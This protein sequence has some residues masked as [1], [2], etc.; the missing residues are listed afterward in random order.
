MAA[1]PWRQR[2]PK[3]EARRPQAEPQL[4]QYRVVFYREDMGTP[5]LIVTCDSELDA[6]V[7]ALEAVEDKRDEGWRVIPAHGFS[8]WR[9]AYDGWVEARIQIQLVL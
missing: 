1:F 2:P 4:G 8:T 5:Q 6:Y 3:R 7:A 9:L